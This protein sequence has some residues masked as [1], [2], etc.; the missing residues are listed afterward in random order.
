MTGG[1]VQTAGISAQ[2]LKCTGEKGKSH[3]HLPGADLISQDSPW[4]L[5]ALC[6]SSAG[7][8]T[9][10]STYPQFTSVKPENSDTSVVYCT[11]RGPI[12]ILSRHLPAGG[13]QLCVS[14]RPLKC[15]SFH[16]RDLYLLLMLPIQMG[17]NLYPQ[18]RHQPPQAGETRKG[19]FS[20]DIGLSSQ[21]QAA[22]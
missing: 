9:S 13:M 1:K 16:P 18:L 21:E 17:S 11:G 19:E 3:P 12:C 2:A 14:S 15:L 7:E 6:Q 10:G 22:Q 20:R 5:E 4:S 8:S